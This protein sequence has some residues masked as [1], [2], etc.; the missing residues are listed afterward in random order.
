MSDAVSK[1]LN[2]RLVCAA[3]LTEFIANK[4]DNAPPL[5]A[6]A[7]EAIPSVIIAPAIKDNP[8][9]NWSVK[10]LAVVTLPQKLASCSAL[11]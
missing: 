5:A 3:S 11:E 8:F 9:V 4:P 6:V 7:A 10:K 2:I 1:P